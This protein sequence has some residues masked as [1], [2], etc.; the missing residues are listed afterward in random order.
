MDVV[1]LDRRTKIPSL[2]KKVIQKEAKLDNLGEELRVLYVALTR[3]KEKLIITG[4]CDNLETKMAKTL[5][6]AQRSSAIQYLD[7]IIPAL[8]YIPEEIP[9]AFEEVLLEEIVRDEVETEVSGKIQE[10]ILRR[11]DT[12]A[13]Y[14][15]NVRQTLEEQFAYQYPYPKSHARKMKFTVSELKKMAYQAELDDEENALGEVVF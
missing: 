7:W 8:A 5:T 4:T 11:W 3:A 9:V 1:D 2:V 6:F 12:S 10:E 15:A 14:D 13:E